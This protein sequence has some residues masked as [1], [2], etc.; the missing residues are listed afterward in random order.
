MGL[1]NGIIARGEHINK[2]PRFLNYPFEDVN[3][4]GLKEIHI[5][6]W[7][8][9]WPFRNLVVHSLRGMA[10][11]DAYEFELSIKDLKWIQ[12]LMKEYMK[13]PEAGDGGYWGKNTGKNTAKWCYQNLFW[14]TKW[15]HLYPDTKFYFYDSY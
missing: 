8:K 3:E 9:W 12:S 6:Y 10:R 7:R 15:W 4:K 5:C 11:E 1:D 2:L 13:D 14:I